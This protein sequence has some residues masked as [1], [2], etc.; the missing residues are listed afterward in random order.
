MSDELIQEARDDVRREELLALWQKYWRWIV[1]GFVLI[2]AI[3]IGYGIWT[4]HLEKQRDELTSHY[5]KALIHIQ[6][7]QPEQAIAELN[8]L[9]MKGNTAYL[10]LSLFK[11]AGVSPDDNDTLQ[12]IVDDKKFDEPWRQLAG[13]ILIERMMNTTNYEIAMQK[14][15]PLVNSNSPWR[16][17]AQ[18]L[19]AICLYKTGAATDAIQAFHTLADD[20]AAPRDIRL[21]AAAFVEYLREN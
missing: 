9:S 6:Q 13:L 4:R 7:K 10:M 19:M 12:K 15:T 18:E 1:G 20:K 17:S 16:A 2:M 11:Q 21:R 14:L 8:L 5:E 3:T